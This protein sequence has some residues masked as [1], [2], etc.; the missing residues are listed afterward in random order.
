MNCFTGIIFGG[1]AHI[2]ISLDNYYACVL[3]RNNFF[4][5]HLLSLSLPNTCLKECLIFEAS[6]NSKRGYVVSMYRSPS[7]TPDDLEKLVVNI[8]SSNPHFIQMIGDSNANSSNWSSNDTTNTEDVLL[9]YLTSLYVMKQ[10]IIETKHSLENSSACINLIF[11]N[12]PSLIMD[13]GMHRTLH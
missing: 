12:R 5:A 2:Y 11:S 10:G 13:S 9:D 7:Q 8:S 1:L 6:F 3:L 4:A